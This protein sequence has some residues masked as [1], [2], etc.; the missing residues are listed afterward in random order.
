MTVSELVLSLLWDLGPQNQAAL[1]NL[2][3]HTTEMLTA[4]EAHPWTSKSTL[5][6]A[7]DPMKAQYAHSI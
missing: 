2:I 4:L 3:G 1:D 7:N 6:W 5:E